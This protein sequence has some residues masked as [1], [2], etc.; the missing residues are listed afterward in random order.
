V[1]LIR[2][3]PHNGSPRIARDFVRDRL[4][5]YGLDADDAA[6]IVSELVTNAVAAARPGGQW[7]T[8]TVTVKRDQV[9][10]TVWDASPEP[11]APSDAGLDAISGRGL[12]IVNEIADTWDWRPTDDGGKTVSATFT[13]KESE[14]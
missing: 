13:A 12:Q 5:Q 1:D 4:A 6:L 9:T 10:I 7:V 3:D 14:R 2:L 8:L 11:P